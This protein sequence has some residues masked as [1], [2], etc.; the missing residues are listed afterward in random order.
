MSLVHIAGYVTRKDSAATESDLLD[1]TTF[2]FQKYG[3]YTKLLDRGG[4][5]VPTDD[6]CQC[7]FF[8]YIMFNAVKDSICRTSL[9]NV[10]MLVSEMNDFGM[11]K[12]HGRILANIF[13]TN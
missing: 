11:R 7:A 12:E 3:S 5:K 8:C 6:A 2:Y 13:M 4:L 10:F 1:T 9:C